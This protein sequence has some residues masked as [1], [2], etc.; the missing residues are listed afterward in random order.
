VSSRQ[1]SSG[2][3]AVAEMALDR[4]LLR[5]HILP[6]IG[7]LDVRAVGRDDRSGSSPSSM[8]R[9]AA[10]SVTTRRGGSADSERRRPKMRGS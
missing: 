7:D 2:C 6:T 5:L 4:A 9:R 1:R 8:R 3:R 10:A